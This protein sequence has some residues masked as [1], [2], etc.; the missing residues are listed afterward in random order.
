M[1]HVIMSINQLKQGD[2]IY[3]H[4]SGGRIP[5]TEK[6]LEER[7]DDE[8]KTIYGNNLYI[9]PDDYNFCVMCMYLITVSNTLPEDKDT[10][11]YGDTKIRLSVE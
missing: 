3:G 6:E 5:K 8:I 1:R 2:N 11:L 4:G 7:I 9:N 10:A